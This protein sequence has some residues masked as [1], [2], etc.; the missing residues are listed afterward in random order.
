MGGGEGGRKASRSKPDHSGS[1]RLSPS[2]ILRASQAR[3]G[4]L[5]REREREALGGI[6]LEQTLASP[7]F[8][9]QPPPS[10]LPMRVVSRAFVVLP[11]VAGPLIG[12]GQSFTTQGSPAEGG[13]RWE[14]KSSPAVCPGPRRPHPAWTTKS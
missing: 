9:H 2:S 8:P 7:P 6:S 5:Q 3:R 13:E 11:Q 14:L 4:G 12:I 1:E 10:S